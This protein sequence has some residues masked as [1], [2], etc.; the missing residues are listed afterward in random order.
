MDF[1]DKKGD[2]VL[3]KATMKGDKKSF[4]QL[5]NKYWDRSYSYA[6][7]LLHDSVA[8]QDVVQDV[9]LNIWL[10]RERLDPSRSFANYLGVAIRNNVINILRA[11][12]NHPSC[13]L[14]ENDSVQDGMQ[15]AETAV[16]D[17]VND[18]PERRRQVVN[19]KYIHGMKVADIARRLELSDKTI[20]R[21]L[22]LARKDIKSGLTS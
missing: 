4:N 12:C 8:A 3:V 17:I 6:L 7:A 2:A 13:E 5:F 14:S 20:E 10:G 18:L 21:H 15:W 16:E 19:M 11:R 22:F 9:F 1:L